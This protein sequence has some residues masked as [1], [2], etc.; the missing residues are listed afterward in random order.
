MLL[1]VDADNSVM[2]LPGN[3][4]H[5]NDLN[6][7]GLC[8]DVTSDELFKNFFMICETMSFPKFG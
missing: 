1:Y 5:C 4:S 7:R 2:S 8:T 3:L 6:V